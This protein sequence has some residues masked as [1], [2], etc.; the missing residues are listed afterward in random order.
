MIDYICNYFIV[1][2]RKTRIYFVAINNIGTEYTVVTLIDDFIELFNEPIQ[3]AM[4]NGTDL[5]DEIRSFDPENKRGYNNLI[6]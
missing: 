5:M 2:R 1:D 6:V 4:E 3:K